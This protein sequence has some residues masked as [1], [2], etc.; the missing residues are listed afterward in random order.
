[1][2]HAAFHRV[3]RQVFHRVDEAER[4]RAIAGVEVPGDHPAGPSAHAGQDADVLLAVRA[5]PR[6][7]LSDDAGGRGELPE[8][9]AVLGG[10]RF[11]GPVHRAVKDTVPRR[12]ERATPYR[13][14]LV[15]APAL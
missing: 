1:M 6:A 5:A 9:L 14:A 3:L 15:H 11:E 4:G 10:E 2:E 7:R 13:E 12:D 8:S